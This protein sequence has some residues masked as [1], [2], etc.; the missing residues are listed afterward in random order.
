MLRARANLSQWK[1]GETK[2]DFSSRSEPKGQ[3][4]ESLWY[5]W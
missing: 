2:D 3:R 1:C 4:M 5:V